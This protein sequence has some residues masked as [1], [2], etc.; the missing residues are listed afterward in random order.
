M[1]GRTVGVL[2]AGGGIMVSSAGGVRGQEVRVPFTLVEGRPVVEVTLAGTRQTVPFVLDTGASATVLNADLVAE[3]G[4]PSEGEVLLA[5]PSGGGATPGRTHRLDQLAIGGWIFRDVFAVS[6]SDETL[7]SGLGGARGVLGVPSLAGVSVEFDFPARELRISSERLTEGDGSLP[8]ANPQ[9]VIPS[10]HLEVADTTVEA[11]VD[12]GNGRGVGLPSSLEH[13][14]AFEGALE[15][16]TGRSA[17][18]TFPIRS[19]RLM[20]RIRLG[21]WELERPQV[22]LNE[23]FP[24]ANVGT[25]ALL[26]TR[27]TVDVGR[28]RIRIEGG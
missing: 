19:G 7:T 3:L 11:H 6:W 17:S 16:G 28:R 23:R 8:F 25:P 1:I 10:L 26:G 13:R 2:F 14:L 9:S 12:T 5:D 4:I 22:F 21:V 15:P 20:G 24:T 18:G 27:T